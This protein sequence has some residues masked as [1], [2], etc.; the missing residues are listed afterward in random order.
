M[1]DTGEGSND[2]KV[3]DIDGT[4]LKNGKQFASMK[5][6]GF[7]EAGNSDGI[8]A[9]VDGNIWSSA[10]WV[11]EGYDGVHVFAS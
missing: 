7:D 11:G 4:S 10:G 6:D 3:W 2:I 8:R 1:A 9:D 5:M